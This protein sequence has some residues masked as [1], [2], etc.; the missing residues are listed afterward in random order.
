MPPRKLL[1]VSPT[2]AARLVDEIL[3]RR[4]RA[5]DRD[6][7]R[8]SDDVVE[9]IRYVATCR[10]VK[11]HILHADTLDAL[12]LLE[13]ARAQLPAG[14]GVWDRLEQQLLEGRRGA[15]LSLADIAERLGTTRQAIDARARRAA[16]AE[17]GLR[18]SEVAD[19]AER[20]ARGAIDR[21]HRDRAVSVRTAMAVF[22]EHAG[23]LADEHAVDLIEIL[24]EPDDD[25]R[26]PALEAPVR[27]TDMTL[28]ARVVRVVSGSPA[29]AGL[30]VGSRLRAAV[31]QGERL[32]AE[33]GELTAGV[34]RFRRD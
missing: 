23:D 33:H 16:A 1:E 4:R 5:D 18:R 15:L 8:A 20:K 3:D 31:E 30:P 21:W 34:E 25:R 22:G 12:E 2:R 26:P 28:L 10:R 29:F 11:P 6:L 32:V 7:P 24:V 27:A 14:P 13:Y 17:K 19:R 9:L